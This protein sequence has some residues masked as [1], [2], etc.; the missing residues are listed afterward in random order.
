MTKLKA[1]A[2]PMKDIKGKFL[3]TV[4]KKLLPQK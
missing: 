1:L 4:E 3:E 2:K